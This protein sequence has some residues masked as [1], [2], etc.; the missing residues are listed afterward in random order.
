ML[1]QVRH[2]A[3]GLLLSELGGYLATPAHAPAGTKRLSNLLRSRRWTHRVLER[4]LW[5]GAARR[6][7]ELAASGRDAIALWDESVLEKPES[8]ALAGLCAVRSARARRLKRMK[9]GFYT[10]PGGPPVF[11]PGMQWLSILVAGWGGPPTLALM[12]WWTTRGRFRTERRPLQTRLLTRCARAWGQRVLHVFDRG[13]AG[14]PWL[15]RLAAAEVRFVVRWPKH[16]QLTSLDGRERKI[17]E[18]LRGKRSC[19]RRRLWDAHRR[20]HFTAGI[21]VL[22]V[23]HPAVPGLALW[24][25]VSRPGTGRPPWY[26]LTNEPLSSAGRV[27]TRAWDVV[28]AYARRW[29]IEMA[30]RFTKSELVMESPRL[31]AWGNRLKLLLMV[32]LVYAFLLSLLDPALQSLREWLLRNWCHRTGKRSRVAA[33]PLYRLRSALSRLWLAYRPKLL[34]PTET[35]G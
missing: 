1:L 3:C 12:R 16:Y 19:A 30:F 17:W 32:T 2:R 23:V 27:S 15:E 11:V 14:A 35:S 18:L 10:P 31:W 21:A 24:L 8:T 26:L 25:V 22:P 33:T 13:F 28:L 5:R 29:Q 4:F 34:L 20:Q 7:A 6:L 9:P